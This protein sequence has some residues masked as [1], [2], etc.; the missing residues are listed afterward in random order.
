MDTKMERRQRVISALNHKESDIIPFHCD[1]T[2]QEH[3]IMADY[4]KDEDFESKINTHLH[5]TQYWGWPTEIPGK[6]GFF[7][8]SYGVEWNRSGVDKDIGVI[9]HPVIKDISERTYVFPAIDHKRIEGDMEKMLAGKQDKYTIGA[10]GFSVFERAWSLLSMEETFMAML[11]EPEAL[12]VLFEE[13]CEYNLEVMDTMLK[14]PI[15]GFYFGDDW[16]QQKGLMMG[17]E[18]WRKF[19][20]PVMKK[21]YARAK[22]KGKYVLQHSCGD[23]LEIFPD[24]IE[25][26][27]DC[28]Q[29]FQPE[30]YDIAKVKAK[31]GNDLCF[32]GGISTQRLLPFATPDVV[33]SETRRIM[34]IMGKGGGYI[35]APTQAMPLD[36]PPENVVAM[37]DIFSN[38]S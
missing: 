35:A 1:F 33:K 27:L 18:N 25:I 8:D 5:Y 38:Q 2:E 19:I 9:D 24:L 23:I 20:K 26:G 37:L 12:S 13:I 22:A 15:D 11:A 17:A 34:D 21:L 28:Y 16:G 36:V 31:F 29:T 6:E 14:Y 7:L 10:I 3:R 4:L 32:W 30:I